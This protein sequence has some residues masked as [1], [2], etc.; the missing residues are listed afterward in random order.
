MPRARNPP[1]A[2]D[3]TRAD[4]R[5]HTRARTHMRTHNQPCA[6]NINFPLSARAA[7][8]HN[9]L[10]SCRTASALR[11]GPLAFNVCRRSYAG[12]P[13]VHAVVR[14]GHHRASIAAA[15]ARVGAVPAKFHVPQ[16]HMAVVGDSDS[17]NARQAALAR[18]GG[19]DR[20]VAFRRDCAAAR[21]RR[22]GH[23]R[24]TR[25]RLHV[26]Q[27]RHRRRRRRHLP[28][29]SRCSSAIPPAMSPRA[30]I[31]STSRIASPAA[32]PGPPMPSMP[33][34]PPLS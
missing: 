12:D 11:M 25:R 13:P 24:E 3:L 1:H 14:Q 27:R 33:P 30:V 10:M 16:R 23:P 22:R 2:H 15:A 32:A 18:P 4:N 34:K 19:Y 28:P 29:L 31:A 6:A 8:H 21:S 26:R 7:P 9:P 20:G 5:F 17:P